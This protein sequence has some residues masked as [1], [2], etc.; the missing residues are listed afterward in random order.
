MDKVFLT[1]V[2]YSMTNFPTIKTAFT[3][4][5]HHGMG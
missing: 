1:C 3:M 4:N 2:V 5:K